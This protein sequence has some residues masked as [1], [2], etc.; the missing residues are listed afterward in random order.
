SPALPYTTLFRSSERDRRGGQGQFGDES[1]AGEVG[2]GVE[3]V[4]AEEGGHGH[5]D[6][7]AD[8]GP[9]GAT[10]LGGRVEGADGRQHHA[11]RRQVEGVIGGDA[12][13]GDREDDDGQV[14]AQKHQR[15]ESGGPDEAGKR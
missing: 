14:P 11:D 1:V 8:D 9:G 7:G 10:Q 2:A 5:E 4:E 6:G 13:D 15:P 12:E 3:V